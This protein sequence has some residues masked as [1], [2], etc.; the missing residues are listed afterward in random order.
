MM[1]R[2][3]HLVSD[4]GSH[5]EP[6][7]ISAP[8]PSRDVTTANREEDFLKWNG[9]LWPIQ[10][11]LSRSCDWIGLSENVPEMTTR[12]VAYCQPKTRGHETM[13]VQIDRRILQGLEIKNEKRSDYKSNRDVR[14]V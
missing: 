7:C 3:T 10:Q 8:A 9:G 13:G 5:V 1:K 12:R 2:A 4:F 11:E 14:N 6:Y